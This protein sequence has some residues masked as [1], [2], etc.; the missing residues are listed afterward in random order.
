MDD[1]STQEDQNAQKIFLTV[2]ITGAA[3]PN[4]LYYGCQIFSK[5]LPIPV[6]C[7]YENAIKLKNKPVL[8]FFRTSYLSKK[9]KSAQK[10]RVTIP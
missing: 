2:T 10:S 4:T 9:T 6:Y 7:K 3:T 1:D 8:V 5:N